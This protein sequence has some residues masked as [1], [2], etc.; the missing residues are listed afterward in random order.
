MS[1]ARNDDRLPWSCDER[2]HFLLKEGLL[3]VWWMN[4]NASPLASSN[5]LQIIRLIRN[6]LVAKLPHDLRPLQEE[7][8][9]HL[10]TI[11]FN[12]P[13]SILEECTLQP[14]GPHRRLKQRQRRMHP[15]QRKQRKLIH[16]RLRIAHP[17]HIPD[18]VVIEEQLRTFGRPQ[19][20][21][22]RPY[23]ALIQFLAKVGHIADS[24]PAKR[25]PE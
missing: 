3:C 12:R 11:F 6:R 1:P 8:A 21:K 23:P 16:C 19:M 25:T 5:Q 24:L 22:H 7:D 4:S 10:M 9:L 13:D 15:R 2:H 17:L 20:Y 14:S 18:P